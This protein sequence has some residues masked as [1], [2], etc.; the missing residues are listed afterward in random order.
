ME[1]ESLKSKARQIEFG[2]WDEMIQLL[3]A[4]MRMNTFDAIGKFS[5]LTTK[6]AMHNIDGKEL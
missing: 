6:R 3:H 1:S 4:D 5:N 2:L